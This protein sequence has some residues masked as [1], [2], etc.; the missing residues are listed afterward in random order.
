[1]YYDNLKKFIEKESSK[2]KKQLK[3]V[4]MNPETY[5][6]ILNE[7]DFVQLKGYIDEVSV[8]KE[9]IHHIFGNKE[10][11]EWRGFFERPDKYQLS[12]ENNHE[13]VDFVMELDQ[14]CRKYNK[15]STS[16]RKTDNSFTSIL[17]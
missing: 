8:L 1:M 11:R 2:W 17:S 3:E 5:Q 7:P 16:Q 14:K 4:K 9:Y 10:L 15:Q 6:E 13:G 12:Y